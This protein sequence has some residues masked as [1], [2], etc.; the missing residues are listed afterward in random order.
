M[1][2]VS[3]YETSVSIYQTIRC[4]TV[5]AGDCS[6][7]FPGHCARHTLDRRLG[8]PQGQSLWQTSAAG[9]SFRLFLSLLA[10]E[11]LLAPPFKLK[12]GGRVPYRHRG[13]IAR[14]LPSSSNKMPG[15]AISNDSVYPPGGG[16]AVCGPASC[17]START[18][19]RT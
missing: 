18:A 17:P 10:A 3:N 13:N 9:M 7:S 6:A 11:P 8:G 19:Y 1:E 15:L 14:N 4:H 5:E 12:I 16:G 2:T